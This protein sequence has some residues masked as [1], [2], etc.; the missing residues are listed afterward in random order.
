MDA[1]NI[2]KMQSKEINS[3]GR[4]INMPGIYKHKDT[5]AEFIT[6][7]GQE[8]VTQADSLMNPLWKDAWER[9]GDVPSRIELLAM[10]K[11]QLVKDTAAE[12]AQ[13]EADKAELEKATKK[14][15]EAKK[16]VVSTK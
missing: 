8:G 6:S 13:K 15:V 1:S 10:Q 12:A 16:E 2:P 7:E 14:V 4:P 11:A 3:D 9:V 5:G